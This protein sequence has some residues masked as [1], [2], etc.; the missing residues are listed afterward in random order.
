MSA[1]GQ[2]MHRSTIG[3]IESAERPATIT[4]AFYLAQ[5]IGVPVAYL[6]G[7]LDEPFID[8]RKKE[9][10]FKLVNQ[11]LLIYQLQGDVAA[12]KEA[13]HEADFQY[14]RAQ[15][16]LAEAMERL[17]EIEIEIAD[18]EKDDQ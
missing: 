2:K 11:R 15:E 8:R 5:V 9:L 4:E 12:R 18:F 6:V 14:E 16:T 17:S 13:C 1:A 3:K 10:A 7:E